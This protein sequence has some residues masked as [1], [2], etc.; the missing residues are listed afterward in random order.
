MKILFLIYKYLL[1]KWH[2]LEKKN[3]KRILKE[4]M[5]VELFELVEFYFE[6]L[7]KEEL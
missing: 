2:K 1:E 5:R 3:T 7:F 4:D 6:L